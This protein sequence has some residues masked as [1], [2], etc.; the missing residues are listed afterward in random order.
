MA[1]ASRSRRRAGSGTWRQRLGWALG[2]ALLLVILAGVDRS[3]LLAALRQAEPLPLI[4]AY[5]VPLP[6]ILLR[7]ARW[8]I[9]LGEEGRH[10]GFRELTTLYAQSIAVGVLTPGRVGELAKAAAVTRRGVAVGS[11]TWS[12]VLDRAADLGFLAVL[13][14]V[15]LGLPLARRLEGG[16]PL[17]L[18][19]AG[20]AGGAAAAWLL[21][22]SGRGAR[23]RRAWVERLAPDRSGAPERPRARVAAPSAA[24]ACAL[25]TAASW[26]LTYAANFLYCRALGLPVGYLEIAAISAVCS[27]VASLPLSIAG[28]G[29]RDAALLALLAPLG[30]SPAQAV[31]LAALMLSNTLFVGAASALAFWV[32]R[33]AAAVDPQ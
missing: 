3:Q 21:G 19:A 13:A 24:A 30:V 2:P 27:L 6:A 14:G 15:A 28:I 9:L 25:L 23:W 8:R 1:A 4:A 5:L 32:P 20:L 26:A 10:L 16:V 29:T 22:A 18:A 11:A 17:A 7:V 12:A 31:A 33:P